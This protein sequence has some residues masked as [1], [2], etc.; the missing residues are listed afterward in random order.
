MLR[1]LAADA[2]ATNNHRRR[3]RFFCTGISCH[4]ATREVEAEEIEN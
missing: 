1:K 4:P 3:Y 2:V